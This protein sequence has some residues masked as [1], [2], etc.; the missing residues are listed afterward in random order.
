MNGI[1]MSFPILDTDAG[2]AVTLMLLREDVLCSMAGLLLSCG[3][4]RNGP[5]REEAAATVVFK[6]TMGWG[7]AAAK[8]LSRGARAS[9]L[10]R[11]RHG[12]GAPA[13]CPWA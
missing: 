8:C 6:N 5:A 2:A 4:S 1:A 3:A 7:L 11:A 13:G 9:A 10:K 12:C